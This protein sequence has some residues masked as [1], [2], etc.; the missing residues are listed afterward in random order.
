MVALY[1]S[2]VSL[3]NLLFEII[4]ASFPDALN[5]SYDN[6]SSGNALVNRFAYNRFSFIYFS[7]VVYKQ[8]LG[9]QSAE[10]KFG[11]KEMADLPDA[12]CRR[13]NHH[14]R[15]DNAHKYISGRRNNGAFR[16]QS[17]RRAYC[18]RSSFCTY[19]L[20]DLRRD[21]GQ[22]SSKIKLLVWA[23]S[24]G[25][26]ASIVGGFFIMGSPFTL[27]MKRFDERRV[28]DLQN[29]QYQVVNFYQRKGVLPNNLDELKDPI[30]GFNI[31]P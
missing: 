8:R 6:F 3:L 16:F 9:D 4:N 19:Y 7:V 27:R 13:R 14:Y 25:V 30:A 29:I 22:K 2:A 20:Y 26:L 12:F 15:F 24:F 31:P 28:N 5:F 23:V 11:H 10:E 1:A 17:S 18:R 21:V